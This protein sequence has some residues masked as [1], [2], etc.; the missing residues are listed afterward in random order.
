MIEPLHGK[1]WHPLS[2]HAKTVLKRLQQGPLPV[3]CINPGV[4]RRFEAEDWVVYCT[5]PGVVM[6]NGQLR[7]MIALKPGVEI[8]RDV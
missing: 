6:A 3:T 7:P 1:T 8:V 5:V 4:R 2:A